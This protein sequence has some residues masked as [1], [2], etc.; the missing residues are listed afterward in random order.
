MVNII[1]DID[2][3][4]V[5]SY[6][7]DTECFIGAVREVLGNVVLRPDWSDYTH[8]TDQGILNEI[9]SDNAI[10]SDPSMDI[11][12]AF[13]A[14]LTTRLRDDTS[15]CPALPG[16][17]EII[18]RFTRDPQVRLGA[19]TGG[20]RASAQ[21]K[22]RHAGVDLPETATF[23]SDI[24]IERTAIMQSCLAGIGD[25]SDPT[26]YIGD[27]VWDVEA[28]QAL[29]WG[30]VGIGPRL[31]GRVAR[32]IEDYNDDALQCHLT[33]LGSSGTRGGIA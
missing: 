13:L 16:A 18:R 9:L 24:A 20:W 6:G 25:P 12:S 15:L 5:E 3:T 14:Q 27:G 26:I 28:T 23:S 31:K 10:A 19:A 1:F 33:E 4:L 29:G 17:A 7:L 21:V 22:L 8:V 30:F 2:G 32:W 11:K